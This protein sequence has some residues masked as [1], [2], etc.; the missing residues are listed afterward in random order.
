MTILYIYDTR[1]KRSKILCKLA[2]KRIFELETRQKHEKVARLGRILN[3]FEDCG[4]PG[5]SDARLAT[6]EAERRHKVRSNPVSKGSKDLLT[7]TS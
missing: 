3:V 4:L 7:P 2:C 6:T 5:T 1:V